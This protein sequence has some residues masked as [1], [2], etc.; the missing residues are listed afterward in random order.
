MSTQKKEWVLV[1]EIAFILWRIATSPLAWRTALF[2]FGF[3]ALL[4]ALVFGAGISKFFLFT[5]PPVL[6]LFSA[7]LAF[8]MLA[9]HPLPPL[10][11]PCVYDKAEYHYDGDF[12]KGLPRKQAFVHTGM[13]VGWL[14][15]HDMIAGGFLEETDGFKERKKTGA[16]IYKAWDGS[17][18]SDVLTDAGNAFAK[19]YYGGADGNGGPYFDDYE[20]TLTAGLPGLYHVKDTWEN[21]DTIKQKIDQRYEAWK[22][23]K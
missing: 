13:F 5:A 1:K 23:Q 9:N 11:G 17:L 20:A 6:L 19:Y 21:Y 22:Q 4:V 7:V 8:R 18:T 2:F 10:Q 3:M 16:Q 15:E 12:P 14:I